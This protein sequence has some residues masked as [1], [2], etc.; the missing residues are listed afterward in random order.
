MPESEATAKAK[1]AAVSRG[2]DV[3]D[4][5][6]SGLVTAVPDSTEDGPHL[7]AGFAKEFEAAKAHNK[8]RVDCCCCC[9][10]GWIV[11]KQRGA[12]ACVEQLGECRS[13]CSCVL[14]LSVPEACLLYH[15]QGRRLPLLLQ[16]RTRERSLLSRRRALRASTH[17]SRLPRVVPDGKKTYKSLNSRSA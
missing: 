17:A 3:G 14:A 13:R 2:A 6:L 5:E 12:S 16:M 11:W 15:L 4:D 1:A 10:S 9:W 8:A 7:P